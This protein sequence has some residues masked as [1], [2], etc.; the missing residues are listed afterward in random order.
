MGKYEDGYVAGSISIADSI[1]KSG[2]FSI[3]GGGDT[4]T[5]ILEENLQDN[6]N[7]ISTGGGAMLDFLVEGTLPG[8]DVI[9]NKV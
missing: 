1:A 6:F 2:S 4:A 7:F 3:T 9:I 8:I 5:V